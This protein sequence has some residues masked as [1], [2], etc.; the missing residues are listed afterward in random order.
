MWRGKYERLGVDVGRPDDKARADFFMTK[1]IAEKLEQHY[2]GYPWFV[3]VSSH[4]GIAQIK[5]P[6]LMGDH[7]YVIHLTDLASDPGLGCVLEAGGQIL[8]RFEM[9]RAGFSEAEFIAAKAARLFSGAS[10]VP[11]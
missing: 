6:I 7:A 5:I 9:P 2:P 11:D 1:Q 4:Q 8:E 3:Q 10:H